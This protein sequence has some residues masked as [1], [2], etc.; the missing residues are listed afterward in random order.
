[1]IL[2]RNGFF[3]L[4]MKI[5]R[6]VQLAWTFL[7]LM[8]CDSPIWI[9]HLLV[10]VDGSWM[11]TFMHFLEKLFKILKKQVY[12]WIKSVHNI[13]I[14]PSMYDY[15]FLHLNYFLAVPRCPKNRDQSKCKLFIRHWFNTRS[16]QGV[17]E[18]NLSWT[19]NRLRLDPKSH[20]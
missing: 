9:F 7:P 11:S 16:G 15:P 20:I 1:M 6:I 4:V 3:I 12:Y 10:W 8:K 17:I 13:Q 14:K 2:P 19:I 18:A 5:H